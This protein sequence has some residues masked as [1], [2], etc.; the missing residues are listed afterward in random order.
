MPTLALIRGSLAQYLPDVSTGEYGEKAA[1]LRIRLQ[2]GKFTLIQISDVRRCAT[3]FPRESFYS[4][5]VSRG[6]GTRLVASL[7]IQHSF[8][9]YPVVPLHAR[10][11]KAFASDI[12][13][14]FYYG[15]DA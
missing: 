15:H 12:K 1:H 4:G 5:S 13:F 10:L 3:S 2:V 14:V 7:H 8:C 9:D 11:Q 6:R